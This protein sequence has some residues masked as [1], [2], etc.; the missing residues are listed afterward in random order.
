[1]FFAL[2]AQLSFSPIFSFIV[3]ISS[4]RSQ[5]RSVCP[6]VFC[7]KGVLRKFPKFTGKHLR[8]SLYFNKAAGLRHRCFPL[9]FAKFLRRPPVAA[10]AGSFTI[11]LVWYTLIILMKK[12]QHTLLFS[13]LP[14]TILGLAQSFGREGLKKLE[15]GFGEN[16]QKLKACNFWAK[17]CTF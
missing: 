13:K 15:Y 8:Q 4:V 2:F 11:M 16:F 6:E 12:P 10:S 14:F 9:N 3:R 5:Y 17:V 7:K 1:M